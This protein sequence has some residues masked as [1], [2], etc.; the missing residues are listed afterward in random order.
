MTYDYS[1]EPNERAVIGDNLMAQ[2]VG[3][4]DKQESLEAEI[5][6]LGE[7]LESK[8]EELRKLANVEIPGL[9]S[10]LT[11]SLRLPDGRTIELAEYIRASIAGDKAGPATEWMEEKGHGNLIKREFIISFNK[12]DEA[13]AKKFE[14]DLARRKKPLAVKIKRTV[15]H[16]TLEAWVKEQLAKGVALPK[17][18]FG[19][20]HQKVSK[21]KRPD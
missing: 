14:R 4:A 2:L 19:I 12:E 1:E 7:T 16:K 20:Y 9:L 3:L 13:W 8:K 10:G 18:V 5:E 15:H 21:V 6:T 11:G 17:D